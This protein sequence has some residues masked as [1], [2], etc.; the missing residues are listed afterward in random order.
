[1]AKMQM[2][3]DKLYLRA[4]IDVYMW[5]CVYEC[6]CVGVFGC[7]EVWAEVRKR[8]SIIAHFP[9]YSNTRKGK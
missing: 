9:I 8:R 5:L 2:T 1:M 3:Y 7:K 6:V 4:G